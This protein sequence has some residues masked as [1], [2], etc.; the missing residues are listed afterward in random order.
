M[1]PTWFKDSIPLDPL[2]APMV[3]LF[4]NNGIKTWAS[5]EGGP[6]H[7][8]GKPTITFHATKIKDIDRVV[9]LLEKNGLDFG[10]EVGLMR[11][12]FTQKPEFKR[13]Y[14]LVQ[15]I[16][17]DYKSRIHDQ[18]IEMVSVKEIQNITMNHEKWV[19]AGRPT[20]G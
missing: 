7:L 1:K 14:G 15:W 3:L 16:W 5:C 10:S 20:L 18:V 6:G 17:D 2:I 4:Q 13:G 11:G 8:W 12:F 9:V 19:R